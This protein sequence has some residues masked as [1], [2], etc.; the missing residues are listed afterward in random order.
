MTCPY[1]EVAGRGQ[2]GRTL[3]ADLLTVR[4][5]GTGRR[6]GEGGRPREEESTGPHVCGPHSWSRCPHLITPCRCSGGSKGLSQ[7][8]GPPTRRWSPPAA[9]SGSRTPPAGSRLQLCRSRCCCREG[10]LSAGSPGDRERRGTTLGTRGGHGCHTALRATP[11]AET[12][13]ATSALAP[14]RAGQF[15]TQT[16]RGGQQTLGLLV[17][18]A[19]GE[20][21]EGHSL[22]PSLQQLLHVATQCRV[23]QERPGQPGSRAHLVCRECTQTPRCR[24]GGTATRS[25]PPSLRCFGPAILRWSSK[26]LPHFPEE[27][28]A[29]SEKPRE[30]ATFQTLH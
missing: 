15:Q 21:S 26:R 4:F 29:A 3:R 23:S 28:G 25:R 27:T 1:T 24:E 20:L 30:E 16:R 7:P 8:A 22:V 14:G 2:A 12:Q 13:G 19:S 6:R 10:P 5:G 11:A 18:A 9:G 17:R